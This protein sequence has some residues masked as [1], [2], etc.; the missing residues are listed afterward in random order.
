MISWTHIPVKTFKMTV[1]LIKIVMVM[2]MMIKWMTF[3]TKKMMNKCMTINLMK[4][5]LFLN[6]PKR[7][8]NLLLWRFQIKTKISLLLLQ[9]KY[10]IK[11]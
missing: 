2:K 7:G 9:E 10:L 6:H 5:I 3:K 4:K 1:E 8:H 11:C